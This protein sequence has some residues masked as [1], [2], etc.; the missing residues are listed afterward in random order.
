M[1]KG[2]IYLKINDI[3][4]NNTFSNKKIDFEKVVKD[5]ISDFESMIDNNVKI[6]KDFAIS[7]ASKIRERKQNWIKIDKYKKNSLYQKYLKKAE[8]NFATFSIIAIDGCTNFEDVKNKLDDELKCWFDKN[9]YATT[10]KYLSGRQKS[11]IIEAL[12]DDAM[13]I[14]TKDYLSNIDEYEE[15][16][17]CI[18]LIPVDTS[19]RLKLNRNSDE[20]EYLYE[21]DSYKYRYTIQISDIKEVLISNQLSKIV[22]LICS[23]INYND[24]SVFNYLIKHKSKNFFVNGE[25]DIE[26][27][28]ICKSLYGYYSTTSKNKVLAS[29]HKLSYLKVEGISEGSKLPI[30]VSLL[31]DV[32]PYKDSN[33][34]QRIKTE[35]GMV[36]RQKIINGNTIKVHSNVFEKL[37]DNNDAKKLIFYLQSRRIYLHYKKDE[38]ML[39]KDLYIEKGIVYTELLKAIMITE[40]RTDRVIKRINKALDAVI[41]TGKILL[42]YSNI[43]D[44]YT[45]QYEPLTDEEVKDLENRLD[46]NSKNLYLDTIQKKI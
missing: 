8:E 9:E 12:K 3:L 35:I 5:S 11:K 46:I 15:M 21:T 14:L 29:I 37:E 44:F 42:G 31:G 7:L 18:N 39:D 4:N 34:V 43:H 38:N 40:K 10:Y 30:I 16:L 24:I 28:D 20:Y 33:N 26:L 45:L 41:K 17:N 1:N 6:N 27:K 23:V 2:D 36:Y 22:N 13:L 19:N 32:L 25:V